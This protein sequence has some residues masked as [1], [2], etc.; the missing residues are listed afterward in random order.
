MVPRSVP[1]AWARASA[2]SRR[3]ASAAPRWRRCVI[4]IPRFSSRARV[5]V[6]WPDM[7]LVALLICPSWCCIVF[8][9][10]LPARA[11]GSLGAVGD[12]EAPF[13]EEPAELSGWAELFEPHFDYVYRALRRW[14]VST[15]DAE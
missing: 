7:T 4:G 10:A 6:W 11:G 13:A 15:A 1:V 9:L 3:A 2:G 14:G 8:L 12:R 5:M